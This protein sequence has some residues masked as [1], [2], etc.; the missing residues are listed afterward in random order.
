VAAANVID[1]SVSMVHGRVGRM[2]KQARLLLRVV[3]TFAAI[4]ASLAIPYGASAA[5]LHAATLPSCTLTGAGHVQICPVKF[6]ATA[7]KSANVVVARYADF[8]QCDTA[9]PSNEPGE[10][11]NYVVAS[12]TINWGDGSAPTS[13]VAHTGTA[14]PAN[15]GSDTNSGENEP[16]TGVHRY[17]KAGDYSVSVSITY[18]RGTGNSYQNCASATAG[19]TAYN[20]LTNCIALGAPAHSI[21]VVKKKKH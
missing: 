7:G 10:N 1:W 12:V 11:Q 16:V 2:S 6:K 8:S 15:D 9:A 14:C 19:D 5:R 17:K 18:V 13:G 4:G 20:A 3:M 21:G